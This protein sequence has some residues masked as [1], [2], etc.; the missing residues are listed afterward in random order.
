MT[1]NPSVPAGDATANLHQQ[2]KIAL[3]RLVRVV[4]WHLPPPCRIAAS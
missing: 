1:L 2:F 3:W 4:E